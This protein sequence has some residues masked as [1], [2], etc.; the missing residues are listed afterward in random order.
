M[1]LKKIRAFSFVLSLLMLVSLF[2]CS[3]ESPVTTQE[4]VA[5]TEPEA[6]VVTTE[7]PASVDPEPVPQLPEN[8]NPLTGLEC[9]A[10][11]AG[12]RPAAIM[13]NNLREALPQIGLSSCDIIYEV[14][15]EG[16]IL[17]LEGVVQNYQAIPKI[18]SVRSARPYYVEL[19]TAYDAIYVHAGRSAL[20]AQYLTNLKVNNL[21]GVEGPGGAAFFRDQDRLNSGYAIEHTMFTSGSKIAEVAGILKY[22]TDLNN[23]EFTAFSFDPAFAGLVNGSSATYI[24]IPHSNYSVSEFRYNAN[25][26]LYYHSQY[27]AAHIDGANNKQISADNVFI[28]FADESLNPDGKTLNIVLTGEGRGYYANGGKIVPIVWKRS[29]NTG[30]FT[31]FNTDGSELKVA[32]GK[33]YVSIADNDIYSAITIS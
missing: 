3:Q 11:L 17:R 32:C 19:A 21:N 9:D 25:D 14:L 8:M 13:F 31:Y 12:K 20:A 15:A 7:E 24:K 18:G 6:V 23:K 2:G 4:E 28:L 10:S 5:S 26:Q 27:G 29:S 16:G 22:R 33:S 1:N 30:S